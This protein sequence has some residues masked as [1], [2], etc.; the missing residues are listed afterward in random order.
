MTLTLT[1]L[2]SGTAIPEPDRFPAGYLVQGAGETVLVDCG[3]GVLRRLAA[4]G[5]GLEDL[6]A[7]LL[8]HFH[9]DHCADVAALLFALRNPRYAGRPPLR[10]WAAPGLRTWLAHLTA[11]WPWLRPRSD[12]D[13]ELRELEPG[14]HRLGRLRVAAY[15]VNHTAESLAYRLTTDE[16]L[17]PL[18]FSGD[19]DE[20]LG[21]VDAARGAR[22]FVCDAAFPDQAYVPGHLTPGRAGRVAA[23]A[24]ATTLCL[25]HFYP[26]CQGTDL[27][28]QARATFGGEVVLAHDSR[29][30]EL[31]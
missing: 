25:T 21:L 3:P 13:L 19:A 11:A 27:L 15:P 9:T 20:G 31:A 12:T 6:T 14:E 26:E 30:F 17:G 7:V 22:L 24:G 5:T 8:T 18:T 2:G 16:G 4:T 10:L 23:A 29:R 1:V 28:A